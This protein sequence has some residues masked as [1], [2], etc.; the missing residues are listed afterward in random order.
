MKAGIQAII[1]KISEDAHRHGS[2]RFSQ[3]KNAIDSEIDGEN[4]VYGE[5]ADKQREVFRKHSEHEYARRIEYQRSRLNR[6]L[7][8][9]QHKLTDEIFD[10]AVAKLRDFAGDELTALFKSEVKWMTGGYTLHLGALSEGKINDNVLREAMEET[11]GLHITL[12]PE[13]IPNKSGFALRNDAVEFNHIFEDLI[14]DVKKKETAPMMKEL[15]GNSADWMFSLT[16]G[17]APG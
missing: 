5:E 14:E 3:V 7:L 11:E 16:P 6:E 13:R 17:G 12:S 2:E 1:M 4:A 15:F 9:Y 10:M 8:L